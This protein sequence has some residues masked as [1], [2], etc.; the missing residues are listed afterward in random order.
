MQAVEAIMASRDPLQ[1][2]ADTR[3][4][5]TTNSL[6]FDLPIKSQN[7]P[8]L[9]HILAKGKE[10]KDLRREIVGNAQVLFNLIVIFQGNSKVDE[11]I[12]KDWVFLKA[13]PVYSST[14]FP[15]LWTNRI[16]LTFCR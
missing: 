15:C 12:F 13:S 4:V 14:D 6:L 16:F 2:L 7:F 3:Y 1:A 5:L 11:R 8:V 10:N 9:A